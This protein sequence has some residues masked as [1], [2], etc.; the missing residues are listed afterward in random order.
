MEIERNN[1]AIANLNNLIE[2][3]QAGLCFTHSFA[4]P[5]PNIFQLEHLADMSELKIKVFS[6]FL[7]LFFLFYPLNTTISCKPHKKK[8]TI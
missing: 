3:I 5:K 2:Q 1:T 6:F 8:T 7:S 4:I